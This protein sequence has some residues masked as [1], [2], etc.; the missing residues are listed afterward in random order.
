MARL[1]SLPNRRLPHWMATLAAP[2]YLAGCASLTPAPTEQE[3]TPTPSAAQLKAH[4]VEPEPVHYRPIPANTLYALLVA[5][6]AGQ[7]QRFDV[8]LHNYMLQAR[9]TGDPEIAERAS[10]IA[11]Y[12][13]ADELA[14]EATDIWLAADPEDP[15]AHHSAAQAAIQQGRYQAAL[16]HLQD[17]QR[18]AGVSQFDYLA[19][20]S[21]QLPPDQQRQLLQQ[22]V[23]LQQQYP[24]NANLTYAVAI[25]HQHLQQF[26]QALQGMNTALEIQPDYLSAGMQKA[27]LLAQLE[28]IE[29]ALVWLEELQ[30]RHAENKAMSVLYAR[31]LLEQRRM[32]EARAAFRDLHQRY[33]DDEALTLSL[34]L[35]EHELD[36]PE[37]ARILL[38]SLLNSRRYANEAHFYLG[39]LAHSEQNDALAFKHYSEV[40]DG[41]EFLPAQ[42]RA[43]EIRQQQQGLTAARRYLDDRR[44]LWPEKTVDLVRIEA[45]LL[46]QDG[47]IPA[48]IELLGQA[49]QLQ[50][51]HMD[52][53]YTRAMLA[54]QIDDIDLLERDLRFIIERQP[55]HAEA[56]NALGYTLADKTERWEEAYALIQ[57]A[58]ELSPNNAAIIDSL[59]W[60]YFRKGKLDKARPLLERAF[61]LMPDHEIAA[62]LGELLWISGELNEARDVWRQGL[63]QTPDSPLIEETLQRLDADL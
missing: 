61:E 48:A 41:R 17:L 35:L 15:S 8:S 36:T 14:A 50:P 59:G 43:A 4:Q 55:D 54:G 3:T 12:V 63:E 56:L 60:V 33:P 46:S 34:A 24:N 25:M 23:T 44:A 9:K 52:L 6:F 1:F 58:I 32:E 5:E 10:R 2:I 21:G 49:L 31:L 53:R 16:M 45:E 57:R 18:L 47:D 51:E 22:F 30:Q 19:A 40:S 28:R 13:G 7:R 26:D 62:H 37:Q 38:Q 11:S 27:R 29:E 42:L 20:N 39:K